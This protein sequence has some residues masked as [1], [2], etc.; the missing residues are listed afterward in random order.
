MAVSSSPLGPFEDKGVLEYLAIDAFAFRDEPSGQLY[1]YYGKLLQPRAML[2]E[3][4]FES[5]YGVK[6]RSPTEVD[7]DH[8]PVQVLKPDQRWWEFNTSSD[9]GGVLA[10]GGLLPAGFGCTGITEGAWI[11]VING[12]YLITITYSGASALT[13]S[14]TSRSIQ[15]RS[16][17]GCLPAGPVSEERAQ[18]DHQNHRCTQSAQAAA[19]T[20]VSPRHS[21]RLRALASS[22]E[23][24]CVIELR[25]S[26]QKQ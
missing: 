17:D 7:R 4:T 11:T 25:I 1:L 10:A 26:K 3:G 20:P 5:I 21:R 2:F 14:C 6:M 15:D 16:L 19:R 18:P 22:I 23:C 8:T 24:E 12:Q 13:A 9:G